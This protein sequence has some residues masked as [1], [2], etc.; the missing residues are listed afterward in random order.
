MFL[1]QDES[2]RALLVSVPA[3]PELLERVSAL[4][5]KLSLSPATPQTDD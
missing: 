2:L 5:Q 3:T 1:L 4:E